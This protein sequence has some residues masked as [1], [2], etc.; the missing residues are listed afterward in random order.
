M[1]LIFRMEIEILDSF[2]SKHKSIT[3]SFPRIIEC[4]NSLPYLIVSLAAVLESHNVKKVAGGV[5]FFPMYFLWG[6]L[7]EN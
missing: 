5:R 6:N 7:A 2:I 3:P 1:F 4:V